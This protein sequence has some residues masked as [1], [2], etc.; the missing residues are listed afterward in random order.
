MYDAD[1]GMFRAAPNIGIKDG[2]ITD[3][4]GGVREDLAQA[5]RYVRKRQIIAPEIHDIH[6]HFYRG[7]IWAQNMDVDRDIH[8]WGTGFAVD[9]G[10]A[11]SIN[12][13][14]FFESIMKKNR[15]IPVLLLKNG[16]LV[17]SKGFRR[18]QNLGNPITAVS[19]LSEWASDELI[20][21]DISRDENYDLRRAD[22]GHPNR[23]GMFRTRSR[24]PNLRRSWPEAI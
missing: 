4:G 17:Q 20:Y 18:Y 12:G 7:I 24:N 6:T 22:L 2:I 1:S 14:E 9:A 16:W 19:R 5:V 13:P 10:S 11:G 8:G 15:L 21:L 23:R 3:I